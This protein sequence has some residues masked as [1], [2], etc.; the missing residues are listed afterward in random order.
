MKDLI[1]QFKKLPVFKK[2]SFLVV[3][4]LLIFLPIA[5]IIALQPK[6][7]KRSKA[8]E[9][10]PTP[11]PTIMLKVTGTI[12][13]G[14][15]GTTTPCGGLDQR[16]CGSIPSCKIDTGQTLQCYAG[17]CRLA[18]TVT[19][20]PK[21]KKVT[22]TPEIYLDD[23]TKEVGVGYYKPTSTPTPTPTPS[24]TPVSSIWVP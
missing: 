21:P 13:G 3:L 1:K 10:D 2:I 12:G 24:P 15:V 8:S 19:I 17:F 20:S 14:R 18:G 5:T 4:F 6:D 7:I 23:D 22:P 16:C 9:P 11:T